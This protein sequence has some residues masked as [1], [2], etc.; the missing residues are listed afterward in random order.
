M[1]VEIDR[2]SKI[3]EDD[4]VINIKENYSYIGS[5]RV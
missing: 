2:S 5:C 1:K 3:E 4:E